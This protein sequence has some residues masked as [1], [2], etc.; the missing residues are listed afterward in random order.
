MDS[1]SFWN[2]NCVENMSNRRRA[3]D[4]GEFLEKLV[5]EYKDTK[6]LGTHVACIY[7][8]SALILRVLY[9][10]AKQQVLANLANFAYNPFNFKFLWDLDVVSLFIGRDR[11]AMDPC[12]Y[13]ISIVH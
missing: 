9:K 2:E 13:I 7:T 12:E 4:R 3:A 8:R 1:L 10:E 6:N 5:Q 11:I